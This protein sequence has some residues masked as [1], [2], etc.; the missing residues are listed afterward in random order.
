MIE[1]LFPQVEVLH[2]KKNGLLLLQMG[3]RDET[4]HVKLIYSRN[5]NQNVPILKSKGLKSL[6]TTS[7]D[8]TQN[9]HEYNYVGIKLCVPL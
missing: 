6:D 4:M 7:L 3:F 8:Q 2:Y 1:Q 5:E 9:S